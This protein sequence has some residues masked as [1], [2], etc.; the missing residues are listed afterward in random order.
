M[1][2]LASNS[3]TSARLGGSCAPGVG[4][5]A[6]G[7][8]D[9]LLFA[10]VVV[11]AVGYAEGGLLAR[12]LGAWQTISWALVAAAPLMFALSAFALTEHPP[13]AT[14]A[15]WG[16]F[17]YL[18]VVSMFLG[19]FAWY[20]GLAL[21]PMAQVSQVQLAQPVLSLAWAALLLH[22]RLGWATM[23]G[24]VVVIGCALFAVRARNR[25]RT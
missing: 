11:C 23:L 17:G 18:A 16:A 9:L 12:E 14:L 13:T 20:R 1:T 8:A 7:W 25:V 4:F 5:G 22:E 6:L 24:G 2:G 19:F 15:E 3:A 21:G 10:A